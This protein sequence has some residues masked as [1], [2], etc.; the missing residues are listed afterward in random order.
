[1]TKILKLNEFF[2]Y[3][4]DGNR[5]KK[6]YR[7]IFNLMGYKN[8]PLVKPITLS[9]GS[10]EPFKMNDGKVLK[11]TKDKVEAYNAELLISKKLDGFAT[12][13]KAAEIT[14]TNPADKENDTYAIL[15]EHLNVLNINS[16]IGKI[17]VFL[18]TDFFKSIDKKGRQQDDYLNFNAPNYNQTFLQL[19]DETRLKQLCETNNQNF[20][21]V[22]PVYNRMMYI[23]K[24]AIDNGIIVADVQIGNVALNSKN[25]LIIFDLGALGGGKNLP[26]LKTILTLPDFNNIA[27]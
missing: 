24:Q 18:K 27:V 5:L 9:G 23:M 25:Q 6:F 1:M 26:A 12:Y 4:Y 3:L 13:Y 2:E 17:Y 8:Q 16:E 10:G 14:F 7:G 19:N 22:K 15:M 21:K 11:I 20:D